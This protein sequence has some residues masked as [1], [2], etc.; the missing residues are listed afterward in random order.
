MRKLFFIG[1]LFSLLGFVN[2]LE[3]KEGGE[4]LN[5]KEALV[6][7]YADCGF[8]RSLNVVGNLMSLKANGGKDDAGEAP[9]SLPA[10]KIAVFRAAIQ[11]RLRGAP[12]R[13]RI[14]IFSPAVEAR[15]NGP[16]FNGI[17]GS[18]NR[19]RRTRKFPPIATL[20]EMDGVEGQLAGNIAG[21]KQNGVASDQ[22]IPHPSVE[23]NPAGS[24]NTWKKM[25]PNVD[26]L[27]AEAG[28]RGKC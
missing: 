26:Y 24:K 6:Q 14:F 11:T 2:R 3:A 10:G 7:L 21:A 8:S 5:G 22:R 19:D 27:T 25:V 12:A 23:C 13:R 17:F 20:V 16:L 9:G 4:S 28:R 18:D 15:L 1:M